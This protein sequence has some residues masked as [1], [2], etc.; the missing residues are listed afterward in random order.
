MESVPKKKKKA[1]VERTCSEGVM[2]DESDESME[3]IEKLT[4]H[5]TR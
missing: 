5:R 3:A 2:D 1:T 4:T